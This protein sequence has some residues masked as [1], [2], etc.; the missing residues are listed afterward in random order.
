MSSRAGIATITKRKNRSQRFPPILQG[1]FRPFFLGGAVWALVVVVLWVSVLTSGAKLATMFDPLVWHRHEMLFGYLGAVIAGFLLTA[2]PNWTGR[3]PITGWRLAMLVGLWLVARLAVL[4]SLLVGA[5]VAAV[6]DVGFVLVLAAVCAREII[7]AK[8][9][10]F[11]IVLIVLLLA[12]ANGLDHADAFGLVQL[13]GSGWRAGFTLIVMLIA[14]IG[15]RIIPTFTRNWLV[16]HRP[17]AASPA[18][19]DR[20]DSVCLAITAI[21]LAGWVAAFDPLAVGASLVAAGGFQAVRL[22]RWCGNKTLREPLV[23]CLHIAYAWLPIGLLLMGTSMLHPGVPLTS[24]LHALSAGAMASMTL[25]V[26]IRATLGHT[27]RALRADGSTV[28]IF[29]L[30]TVGAAVRVAAPVL[31]FDYNRTVGLAGFLWGGAFLL[32]AVAYGPKLL[33]NSLKPQT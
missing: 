10:N 32:F 7:A 15:G 22:S 13:S 21:S 26:M 14:V 24:A 31:P 27:G 3:P 2:I 12:V 30:V 20:F 16:K 17:T 6:F 19:P 9:R 23:L 5:G 18:P 25:A 1:G 28:A 33:G 4:F 29:V 11:P 8:N